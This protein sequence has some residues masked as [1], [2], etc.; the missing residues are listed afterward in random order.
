LTCPFSRLEPFLSRGGKQKGR[1]GERE[2][3]RKGEREKGRKG[4]LFFVDNLESYF[5]RSSLLTKNSLPFSSSPFL[6]FFLPQPPV[7]NS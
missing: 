6:P 1:K 7:V 2:K 3:R 4:D 5:S